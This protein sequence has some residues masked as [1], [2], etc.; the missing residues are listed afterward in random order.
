MHVCFPSSD[1]LH[2]LSSGCFVGVVVHYITRSDH[3]KM[4]PDTGQ[5]VLQHGT[6]AQTRVLVCACIHCITNG[7][8]VEDDGES[9][10]KEKAAQK[11][12]I[13]N[14]LTMIARNRLHAH[15]H[16]NPHT[17]RLQDLIW[18]LW[19]IRVESLT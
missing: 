10:H 17:G 6:H 18:W 14:E 12:V 13:V 5:E 16:T 11:H 15:A 1:T 8:D 7:E 4:G 3:E 19:C 2:I 9:S